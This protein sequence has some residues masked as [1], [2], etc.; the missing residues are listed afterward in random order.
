MPDDAA[1]SAWVKAQDIVY[2]R[3]WKKAKRT[4]RLGKST[5]VNAFAENEPA[6][7]C[8]SLR[9]CA[10]T[11]PIDQVHFVATRHCES[12][13]SERNVGGLGYAQDRLIAGDFLP[14]GADGVDLV[15]IFLAVGIVNDEHLGSEALR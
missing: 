12:G 14:C 3:D 11:L 2:A 1:W 4:R 7:L 9:D 6:I 8:A 10:A 13:Y 5:L 15:T